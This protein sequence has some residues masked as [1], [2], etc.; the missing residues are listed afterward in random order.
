[1]PHSNSQRPKARE[2]RIGTRIVMTEGLETRFWSD[3]YHHAMNISW[4]VFFIC[5]AA[6]FLAINCFFAF[7]YGFG[8][9]PIAN[10]RPDHP[11]DLFFSRSR[12]WQPWVMAICTHKQ[13]MAISWRPARFLSAYL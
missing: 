12:R 1:M 13:P 4:P 6:F 11:E 2:V 3:F 9:Q 5:C 8:D 7:L 10:I